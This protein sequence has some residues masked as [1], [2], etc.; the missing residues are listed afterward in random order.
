MATP[1]DSGTFTA[2]ASILNLRA[3]N[4]RDAHER[5][6]GMEEA[7][8]MMTALLWA[9][10]EQALEILAGQPRGT[11]RTLRQVRDYEAPNVSEKLVRIIVSYTDYVRHVVW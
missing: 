9:R 10:I 5:P 8:V 7:A 2:E 4:I 6:E 1:S 11:D 3:P